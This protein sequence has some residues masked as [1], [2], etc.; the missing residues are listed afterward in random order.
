[1]G[2][3]G[4]SRAIESGVG[5]CH[6]AVWRPGRGTQAAEFRARDRGVVMQIRRVTLGEGYSDSIAPVVPKWDKN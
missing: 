2:P 5:G 1:M 6:A 3:V 4:G